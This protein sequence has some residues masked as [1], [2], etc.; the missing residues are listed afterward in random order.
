MLQEGSN[1]G[2]KLGVRVKG[3]CDGIFCGFRVGVH[4]FSSGCSLEYGS[5]GKDDGNANGTV[6]LI[7]LGNFNGIL[8]LIDGNMLRSCF[9]K[10]EG[11]DFRIDEGSSD[12]SVEERNDGIKDGKV[13]R[14]VFGNKL[15]IVCG[16]LLSIVAGGA[17]TSTPVLVGDEELCKYE[18][19]NDGE[20]LVDGYCFSAYIGI[21]V[22]VFDGST[23]DGAG[24]GI[25]LV[26]ING[27]QIFAVDGDVLRS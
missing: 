21:R 16:K 22:G 9:G 23:D 13:D 8:L 26:I 1:D 20:M 3:H 24:L 19:S 17:L 11:K 25:K 12:G 7:K 4:D 2:E 15:G 27:I 6:L 14:N 5:D 18:G 10:A